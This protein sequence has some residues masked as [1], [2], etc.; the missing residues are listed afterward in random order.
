[1]KTNSEIELEYLADALIMAKDA[2]RKANAARIEIEDKIL[3]LSPA[4]E[5]GSSSRTLANGYRLTCIGKVS[6]KADLDKL[7]TITKGWPIEYLPIK[8]EVKADEKVLKHIR[9]SRPDL[10]REVAL[11]VTTQPMKTNVTIE[12]KKNGV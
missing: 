5:E 6:Y 2:E 9:A 3:A 8:T 12:E 4:K 10:W 1:M 11:A 7:I